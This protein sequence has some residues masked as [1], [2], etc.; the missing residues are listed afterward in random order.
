MKSASTGIE[1][2]SQRWEAYGIR[3]PPS[4]SKDKTKEKNKEKHRPF[5][6][7][8]HTVSFVFICLCLC[9]SANKAHAGFELCVSVFTS[10]MSPE[11]AQKC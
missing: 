10:I 3:H 7:T 5:V 11:L 9:R 4:I 8:V 6:V 2:G 1:P